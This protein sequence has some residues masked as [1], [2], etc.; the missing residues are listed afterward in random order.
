MIEFTTP[1]STRS[2]AP[3]VADDN[4]LAIYATIAATSST[5]ANR[6]INDV[7]QRCKK[8]SSIISSSDLFSV[9]ACLIMAFSLARLQVGPGSTELIVT[10]VPLESL[11]NPRDTAS[12]AVLLMP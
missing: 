9:W 10:F 1:P 5:S 2:A 7:G 6:C 8:K 11:A 3:L 4:G 12:C